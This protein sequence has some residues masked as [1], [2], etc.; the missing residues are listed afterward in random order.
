[1]ILFLSDGRLGNQLFQY[2]FL[3]TIAAEDEIIYTANMDQFVSSFNY[4]CKAFK[5]VPLGRRSIFLI[6]RF[7][8]PFLRLA[9]SL[10]LI[11]SIKQNRTDISALSSYSEKKGLLPITLVETG[12]FQ[13]ENFFLKNKIDF[14]LKSK[15]Q[16]EAVHVLRNIPPEFTKVFV[17]VRRGDYL[18]EVYCGNRGIDLPRSYFLGA[19][20]IISAEVENPY[21]IFLSDDPGYVECCFE[22]IENKYISTNRMEVDFALMTLCNY[23]VVSNSSFSWWGAYMMQERRKVIFPKYWYGWKEKV[24]SHVDIH[25]SWC[26]VIDVDR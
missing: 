24:D 10:R 11:R 1:M 18:T 6:R 9:C 3:R 5:H 16:D 8:L 2:A 12:F 19:I 23:G 7:F 22:N 26:E 4:G 25:P 20:D 15:F 17:H 21:Y 14:T 13:S